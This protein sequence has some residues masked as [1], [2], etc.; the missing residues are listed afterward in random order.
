MAKII[1]SDTDIAHFDLMRYIIIALALIGGVISAHAECYDTK[2][3]ALTHGVSV[4]WKPGC[5]YNVG[6]HKER[7]VMPPVRSERSIQHIE[8][9]PVSAAGA[10]QVLPLAWPEARVITSPWMGDFEWMVGAAP[11]NPVGQ[12]FASIGLGK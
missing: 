8:S 9:R 11:Y 2:G 3:E 10:A 1:H 7:K 5:Y 4:R 12:V 6:K